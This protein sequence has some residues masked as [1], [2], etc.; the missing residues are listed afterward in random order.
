[1]ILS[2]RRPLESIWVSPLVE[3]VDWGWQKLMGLHAITVV[4]AQ[5]RY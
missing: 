5:E 3:R 2:R 1:M 4:A